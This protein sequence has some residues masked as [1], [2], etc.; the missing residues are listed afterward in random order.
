MGANIHHSRQSGPG[1]EAWKRR[2]R[3]SGQ[4]TSR[5]GL[6]WSAR[7]DGRTGDPAVDGGGGWFH[8]AAGLLQS[9]SA[10]VATYRGRRAPTANPTLWSVAGM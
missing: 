10:P 5:A 2:R 4:M 8:F 9:S 3:Y 1:L 7:Y 6:G